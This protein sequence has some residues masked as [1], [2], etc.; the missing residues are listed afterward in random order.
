MKLFKN[1]AWYLRE[2]KREKLLVDIAGWE[3][4]LASLARCKETDSG[5]ANK[6]GR[7]RKKLEILIIKD[8]G[9]LTKN[10]AKIHRI[11]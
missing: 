6:I 2:R 7:A 1:I 3:A 5:I 10:K 8:S 11:K 4:E 9:K